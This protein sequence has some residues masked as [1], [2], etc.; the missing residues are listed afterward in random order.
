VLNT[1]LVEPGPFHNSITDVSGYIDYTTTMLPLDPVP[2]FPQ[3]AIRVEL[4]VH[5][6]LHPFG[7]ENPVWYVS[8]SSND[9]VATISDGAVSF[10]KTYRVTGRNDGISLKVRFR[11][12]ATSVEVER[13]WL[14]LRR[15]VS[16][17]NGE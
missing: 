6:E 13:L 2:P 8:G 15:D 7:Y 1:Q 14:E 5:A 17:A 16:V 11:V 10:E 9:D 12:S 3:F 4:S